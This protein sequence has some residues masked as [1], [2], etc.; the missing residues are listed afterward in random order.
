MSGWPVSF[1]IAVL[2]ITLAGPA[3]SHDAGKPAWFYCY[4][5]CIAALEKGDPP[6]A[7]PCPEHPEPLLCHAIEDALGGEGDGGIAFRRF[8]TCNSLCKGIQQ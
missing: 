4:N 8:K 5:K 2:A 3:A 7:K 6:P 1:A